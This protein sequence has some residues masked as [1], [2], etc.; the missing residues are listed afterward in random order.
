[1]EPKR[2][3][4]KYSQSE[5]LIKQITPSQW[6]RLNLKKGFVVHP[7]YAAGKKE[8]SQ[9]KEY[10]DPS[11]FSPTL[12]D[13]GSYQ[14]RHL[15]DP[16]YDFTNPVNVPVQRYEAPTPK[17]LPAISPTIK[18]IEF[19]P[20]Y[21]YNPNSGIVTTNNG[22]LIDPTTLEGKKKGGLVKK[23]RKGYDDGG[24]V[25]ASDVAGG[26]ASTA[27]SLFSLVNGITGYN[28]KPFAKKDPTQPPE[29]IDQTKN[30][31]LGQGIGSTAGA[32]L[33][34]AA[35]AIFGPEVAPLIP[36]IAKGGGMAGKFIGGKFDEKNAKNA[37][38]S[39]NNSYQVNL[40]KAENDAKFQSS[41]ATQFANRN[42]YS[43]GGKIIGQGTGTSDSIKAK[44]EPGSFVIP[45]KNAAKAKELKK[46]I[47]GGDKEEK[48]ELN[49][50]GGA[51][52]RLSNGEYVFSPEEKAE[53]EAHGIDLEALAP[54]AENDNDAMKG[55]GL[56]P[57]KAKEILRD[58]TIRG[59]N[60]TDKQ[61]RYFGYISDG[62]KCGGMVGYSEGGT[63]HIDPSH[64]GMFTRWAS[65]NGMSVSKAASHVMSNKDNYSPH[66]VKMANFA[67]NAKGWEHKNGGEI[68]GYADGGSV[69]G[70]DP[71]SNVR[72][73]TTEASKEADLAE[74][75][76][77]L[78][79]FKDLKAKADSGDPVAKFTYKQ[80]L[81]EIGARIKSIN[82][83][84]GLTNTTNI[85]TKTGAQ[86][87]KTF[88]PST[89]SG[90]AKKTTPSFASDNLN[91]TM[92]NQEIDN[93]V[94]PP[95]GLANKV[96]YTPPITTNA[97]DNAIPASATPVPA[98]TSTAPTT[99][100]GKAA[101]NGVSS[102]INYGVPLVQAGIGL[103]FLKKAGPRPIDKIDPAFTT[104]M[105]NARMRA[106]YGFTPEEQ[107]LIN[108]N[109]NNLT[110]SQRFAARNYSGGSAGNA[111][112]MERNAINDSYGRGLASA[113]ANRNLQLGKQ[114]YADQF[115]LNKV[116]LS[117]RL[118]NDKMNA[119]QQNQAAG[120][121]LLGAGIQN[122]IGA[123]RYE[124]E[125][126]SIADNNNVANNWLGNLGQ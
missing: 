33:G 82:E 71:F 106:N 72:K 23:V 16:N 11:T 100:Y 53:L 42:G 47:L 121:N 3:D 24:E 80:R 27:D 63:I 122:F 78:K 67:L 93:L 89:G 38:N 66:V 97:I 58:G 25:S 62:H 92:A 110:S 76:A 81:P 40:K 117:R 7:G 32:G 39:D 43:K 19:T 29:Y 4:V 95:T 2:G 116:E 124:Q 94:S 49:Q 34:I 56:T 98:A 18:P 83:K 17:V 46:E 70:E 112:A 48:A 65:E 113:V 41:L 6:D 73:K 57:A 85:P 101:L 86:M 123:N 103:N 111:Y 91:K 115:G 50:H 30:A 99:N 31:N 64:K 75:Q 114:Q 119:W 15:K 28:K 60:I 10:Y 96:A 59:K 69:D 8:Q 37:Y 68:K 51:D 90:L 109:N 102:L 12:T 84:H 126:Q 77:L 88:G 87:Q 107:T 55:G 1:M 9:Y 118:F 108:N 26:E 52:I 54:D 21:S 104:A 61:R 13:K 45:K 5:D 36:L 79:E 105:E 120:Q 35:T 125:K 14:W 22:Q 74:R 44:V 20:D